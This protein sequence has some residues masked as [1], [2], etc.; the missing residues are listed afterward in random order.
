MT[1]KVFETLQRFARVALP[2]TYDTMRI[3]SSV[4]SRVRSSTMAIT[5]S[6]SYE[7]QPNP[8]C[9][10]TNRRFL[11]SAMKMGAFENGGGFYAF[12]AWVRLRKPTCRQQRWAQRTTDWIVNDNNVSLIKG[13]QLFASDPL[14]TTLSV[15]KQ[16]G[17]HEDSSQSTGVAS[18]A[19]RTGI[20]PFTEGRYI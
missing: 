7:I 9:Q 14:Q 5:L 17:T 18:C 16:A 11:I 19:Y 12:L 8:L 3:K 6:A 13:L 20:T 15:R 1:L 4:G 2:S 10:R